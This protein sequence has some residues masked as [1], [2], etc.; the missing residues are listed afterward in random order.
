MGCRYAVRGTLTPGTWP[1][2]L[3]ISRSSP[4][5]RSKETFPDDHIMAT[6]RQPQG[7]SLAL[8]PGRTGFVSSLRGV[9][10]K[11]K[12]RAQMRIDRAEVVQSQRVKQHPGPPEAKR[13]SLPNVRSCKRR[14]K[15]YS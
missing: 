2:G 1:W 14:R 6:D 8:E 10:N 5:S 3:E 12:G 13:K 15:Q 4:I 9:W 11:S 7:R